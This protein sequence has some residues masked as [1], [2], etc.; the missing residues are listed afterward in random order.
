MSWSLAGS[1]CTTTCHLMVDHYPAKEG[2]TV[3]GVLY[4][5][6]EQELDKLDQ[7][8][9]MPTNYKRACRGEDNIGHCRGDLLRCS[10]R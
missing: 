4:E 3:Y 2:Q 5:L 10:R 1:S 9:G 7:H 6:T 8:E